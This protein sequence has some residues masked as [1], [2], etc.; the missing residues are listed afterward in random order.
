[1]CFAE[2][3]K[4]D[5]VCPHCPGVR[6]MADGLPHEVETDGVRDDGSR[7]TARVHAFPLP[8]PGGGARGFIEVVEDITEKKRIGQEQGQGNWAFYLYDSPL[9]SVSA[10][11]DAA[12]VLTAQYEYDVFGAPRSTV[13]G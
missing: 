5:A 1:M 13:T 10:L 11:A 9:R 2:F 12:G 6:A 7:L 3:E 4:R 8:A